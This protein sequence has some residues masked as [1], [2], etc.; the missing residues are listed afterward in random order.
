MSS[1][2]SKSLLRSKA[3]I[4]RDYPS[5]DLFKS[6]MNDEEGHVD[7]LETQID[8]INRIGVDRYTQ[9]HISGLGDGCSPGFRSEG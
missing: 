7:F 9:A 2:T 6:L 5:R 8:L 1:R 4:P 3:T